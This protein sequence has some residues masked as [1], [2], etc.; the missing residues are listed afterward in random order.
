MVTC[1]LFLLMT[2]SSAEAFLF[3]EIS[4]LQTF[5]LSG[6]A[7][8]TTYEIKYRASN[9]FLKETEIRALFKRVDQSLSLYDPES[10]IN[11]FNRSEGGI[12]CDAY[13]LEVLQKSMEVCRQSNGAFD[14]TVKPLVDLWG[15]GPGGKK[16]IPSDADIRNILSLIGCNK[17]FL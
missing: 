2:I 5:V 6:S 1:W 11:V 13:L 12:T 8:G 7:Q 14:I 10:L 15:F 4:S 16:T 9:N 17:V 3:P